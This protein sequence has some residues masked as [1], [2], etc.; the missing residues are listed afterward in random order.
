MNLTLE[1][2]EQLNPRCEI[3]HKNT[4]MTFVTPGTFAQKRVSSIYTKEPCTLEWIESFE[5]DDILLDIGANIGMYSIWAAATRRCRVVACEPESQNYHVLNR[6]IEI[7]DLQDRIK[8]YC[9]GLSD[10]QGFFDL[11]MADMRIGGSNHALGEPLDFKNEPFK[12]VNFRQGAVAFVLD[13]LIASQWIPVPNHIKID[14]D[15]IEP[16]I[17]SGAASLIRNP[18]VRSLLIETNLNLES[19]RLMVQQLVEAGFKVDA[20]QVARATRQDGIFKGVAEHVF[21]R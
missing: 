20:E 9:I 16:K 11:H 12:H 15:G 1:Q 3:V 7:N 8:A 18:V 17:I 14:V 6:N 10:Q 19:H 5:P 21:R 2:Y 4:K 13:Q